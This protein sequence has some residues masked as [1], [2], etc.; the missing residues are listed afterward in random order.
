MIS[1]SSDEFIPGFGS[2]LQRLSPTISSAKD[3][4][5]DGWN[6][7]GLGFQDRTRI[8]L[9][10][11]FLPFHSSDDFDSSNIRTTNISCSIPTL[12]W[13]TPCIGFG[14]VESPGNAGYLYPYIGYSRSFKDIFS[15]GGLYSLEL[16]ADDL[17]PLNGIEQ[18]GLIFN[19][20]DYIHVGAS[21]ENSGYLDDIDSARIGT[22]LIVPIFA[23]N[24]I[25]IRSDLNTSFKDIYDYKKTAIQLHNLNIGGDIETKHLSIEGGFIKDLYDDNSKWGWTMNFSVNMPLSRDEA[26]VFNIDSVVI[27][28][29]DEYFLTNGISYVTGESVKGRRYVGKASKLMSDSRYEIADQY[30]QKSEK[31]LVEKDNIEGV[32]EKRVYIRQTLNDNE[33]YFRNGNS[34]MDANEFSNAIKEFEKIPK[35]SGFYDNANRNISVTKSLELESNATKSYSLGTQK[36]RYGD[37]EGA[38]LDFKEILSMKPEYRDTQSLIKMAEERLKQRETESL[39]NE[40]MKQ[41]NDQKFMLAYEKFIKIDPSYKDVKK[42]SDICANLAD[43]MNY[44]GQLNYAKTI[45]ICNRL[46]VKYPNE[47]M[48]SILLKKSKGNIEYDN[49]NLGEAIEFWNTALRIEENAKIPIDTGIKSR[50]DL[51]EKRLLIMQATRAMSENKFDDALSVLSQLSDYKPA[52]DLRESIIKKKESCQ[53]YEQA[54]QE[55]EERRYSEAEKNFIE[56]LEIDP[57][58]SN[59]LYSLKILYKDI[60]SEV[61]SEYSDI[62]VHTDTL[63]IVEPKLNVII[64]SKYADNKDIACSYLYLGVIYITIDKVKDEDKAKE[65]FIKALTADL[66]C[67]ITPDIDFKDVMRVFESS[68]QILKSIKK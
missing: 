11:G 6:V 3:K 46:L 41:Y 30:L 15:I 57:D 48:A 25:I 20:F 2:K 43:A 17:A 37:Y 31:F 47:V 53:L 54:I 49:E 8:G 16:S 61:R 34:Y 44:Y 59:A 62:Y 13:G 19:F 38:I 63:G 66:K 67:N 4:N 55:Y 51:V 50:K 24:S 42:A 5:Y 32:S 23:G 33:T 12:R 39:Y 35:W 36:L 52:L 64:E 45:E 28:H 60:L 58:N 26:K 14:S 7:A 21:V 65:L 40:A 10:I 56:C 27:K 1:A 29:K 18:L 9:E 22:A 68:K